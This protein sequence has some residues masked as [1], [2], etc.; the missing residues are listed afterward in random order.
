VGLCILRWG[1]CIHHHHR[2]LVALAQNQSIHRHSAPMPRGKQDKRRKPIPNLRHDYCVQKALVYLDENHTGDRFSMAEL[3]DPLKYKAKA[4]PHSK[5]YKPCCTSLARR[6]GLLTI[7]I[8]G[9]NNC[10][11]QVK[12]E[13]LKQVFLKLSEAG[14][15]PPYSISNTTDRLVGLCGCHGAP[16]RK[17]IF[18]GTCICTVCAHVCVYMCA[19]G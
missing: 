3:V 15:P 7:L 17:L 12:W 11:G 1:L 5:G 8:R 13:C 6:K 2:S 19:Y 4:V 16:F 18:S 14:P 9:T 10:S